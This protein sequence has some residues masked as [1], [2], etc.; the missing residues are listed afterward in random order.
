MAVATFISLVKGSFVLR[1]HALAG[2]QNYIA[3]LLKSPMVPPVSTIATPPD[4]SAESVQ[5]ARRLLELHFGR[6]EVVIVLDGP[7]EADMAI[8]KEEFK[9]CPSARAIGK[10]LPTAPIR[11]VYE[12]KDPIRVV[13]IDKERGGSVDAWNAAVNACSSPVIGLIDPASEFPSE[14]LLR[15]IQPMLEA[16]EET[17]GICGG[18][19]VPA[20]S[21]LA[22]RFGALES[23]RAWMTRGAALSDENRTLPF[24]G[25]AM[26]VRRSAVITGGRLYRRTLGAFPATARGSSRRRQTLPRLYFCRIRSAVPIPRPLVPNCIANWIAISGRS[27]ALSF[28]VWRL[29]GPSDGAF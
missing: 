28:V 4:A 20:G 19:S 9:L 29:P 7:S 10:K 12:S 6:N 8:W 14:I 25:A 5:F 26:L 22:A 21:G 11:G 23:L 13:V 2:R 15:L 1:R 18:V 24:P 17:I 16:A 3:A 27:R